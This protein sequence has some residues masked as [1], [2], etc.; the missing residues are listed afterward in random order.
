METAEPRGLP[1]YLDDREPSIDDPSEP[2]QQTAWYGSNRAAQKLL[3][4]VEPLRD[5]QRMLQAINTAADPINDRRGAKL[6]VTPLH[7][8]AIGVRDLFNELE[9]NAKD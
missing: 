4:C 1:I 8:L 9:G 3:R 2:H 6:L 7:S 5:V